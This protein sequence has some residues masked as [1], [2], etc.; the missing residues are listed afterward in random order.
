M[1]TI[2]SVLEHIIPIEAYVEMEHEVPYTYQLA[3]TGGSVTVVGVNHVHERE[4]P[5]FSLLDS[6][7][8]HVPFDSVCVEGMDSDFKEALGRELL[9]RLTLEA[10]AARG[11][12]AVYA[13][14]H[15]VRRGI[16]WQP[17]EPA[18]DILFSYVLSL[19]FS[20]LDV[21]TWYVLRLLPQYIAQGESL[22]FDVYIE[23]FMDEFRQA[24]KW[25]D[26]T[27]DAA[28]ILRYAVSVLQRDLVLHNYERAFSYTDPRAVT[29]HD[30]DFTI[31][32]TI[33]ATADVLR[34]RTMV[35]KVL[36]ELTEGKRVLL[37]CGVAHAVMQ[38]PAY[39]AFI[40]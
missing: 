4:H 20:K 32:N 6:I 25:L 24:T 40:A 34:D 18:D 36:T 37:V 1:R 33:S 23:P 17:V 2:P 15:A 35:T 38:E 7:F 19:G 39:R 9:P 29:R 5:A 14:V 22:S 28:D 31:F 30:N 21:V 16:T 26:V 8:A 13:V 10:A 3:A 12:E 11:G 27:Y